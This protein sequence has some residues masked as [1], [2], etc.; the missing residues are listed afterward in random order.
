M[1]AA[2]RT[3][4][5]HTTPDGLTPS[6]LPD[7][8]SSPARAPPAAHPITRAAGLAF[9]QDQKLRQ[10]AAQPAPPPAAK[11]A[12][13][14]ATACL[15]AT[16]RPTEDLYTTLH[17]RG[18]N[19]HWPARRRGPLQILHG[20]LSCASFRSRCAHASPH[21]QP[22][23]DEASACLLC[24]HARDD[25]FHCALDCAHTA[26][27]ALHKNRWRAAC[28]IIIAAVHNGDKGGFALLSSAGPHKHS[29]P[30]AA[31]RAANTLDPRVEPLPPPESTLP[32]F[33]GRL[34]PTCPAT[35]ACVCPKG[36]R[37]PSL[38]LIDGWVPPQDTYNPA[39]GSFDLASVP[40]HLLPSPHSPNVQL[41]P[42]NIVFCN[43]TDAAA[44]VQ[45]SWSDNAALLRS[46]RDSRWT[47]LGHSLD[48]SPPNSSPNIFTIPIGVCGTTYEASTTAL[49]AL[50]I[51]SLA[52]ARALQL[53]LSRAVVTSVADII[54]KKRGLEKH[55]LVAAPASSH[56]RSSRRSRRGPRDDR[57][58]TPPPPR[59]P[60]LTTSRAAALLLQLSITGAPAPRAAPP[61][62]P[63]L[64]AR[65]R[66][67]ARPLPGAQRARALN[68][69]APPSSLAPGGGHTAT[70]T[71]KKRSRSANTEHR[72][73]QPTNTRQRQ[74]PRPTLVHA[75]PAAPTSITHAGPPAAVPNI[76]ACP[77]PPPHYANPAPQRPPPR[78]GEPG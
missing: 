42:V 1:A 52:T 36:P 16:W 43:D 19:R 17:E 31:A 76:V 73:N 74:R 44:A 28:N 55:L 60:S 59:P 22:A 33:L 41:I 29:S 67:A 48:S 13:R 77:A 50:G 24:R 30:R 4:D 15:S 10:L 11:A 25:A 70:T 53:S 72:P 6:P 40:D 78:P 66:V 18:A 51:P 3:T 71:T 45:K 75:G 12:Y 7:N 34:C 65:T 21:T 46:L 56:R 64:P 69:L 38:L 32:S 54:Q 63:P 39:T 57:T 20:S 47:V 27:T 37:A 61:A 14:L 5:T 35:A 68:N 23:T 58:D 62:P 2:T 26:L 8:R 49:R 9:T